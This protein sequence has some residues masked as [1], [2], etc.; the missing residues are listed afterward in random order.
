MF[1]SHDQCGELISTMG[2]VSGSVV[3]MVLYNEGFVLLTSSANISS[4]QDKYTTG[5]ALEN[6][7]W[8]Y[9]GAYE[10]GLATASLFSVSFEGTQKIPTTTMFATAQPGDLN[11]SLNPTWYHLQ[12]QTGDQELLLEIVGT[13]SQKRHQL[14]TP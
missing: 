3:G 13:L 5:A 7:S 4:N 8:Q 14:R 6:A 9:F 2:G 12:Q 10:S 11:N 1:P